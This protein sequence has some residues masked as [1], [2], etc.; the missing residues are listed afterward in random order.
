MA[1]IPESSIFKSV[2]KRIGDVFV[3]SPKF[4]PDASGSERVSDAAVV[5][6]GAFDVVDQQGTTGFF[7]VKALRQTGYSLLRVDTYLDTLVKKGLVLVG[8]IKRGRTYTLSEAG[9]V[10]ARRLAAELA[11]IAGRPAEVLA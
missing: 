3:L 2:T 11:G 8:G 5:L 6:L 4:P 1:P 9:R 7:L 10:E